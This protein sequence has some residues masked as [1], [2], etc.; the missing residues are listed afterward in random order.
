MIPE[1]VSS[2]RPV[3]DCKELDSTNP[4]NI[5]SH[6]LKMPR[7]S[8]ENLLSTEPRT[9]L[10]TGFELEWKGEW[11]GFDCRHLVSSAPVPLPRLAV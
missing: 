8:K 11:T 4:R 5:C 6:F 3:N 7:R 1:N 2:E 9:L 10:L